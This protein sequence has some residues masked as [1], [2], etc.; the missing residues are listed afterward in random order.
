MPTENCH[1]L[2]TD[3]SAYLD[4][5]ASQ[6]LCAELERHLANCDDCTAVVD[7]AR[8]TVNLYHHLPRPEMPADARAR[9]FKTLDLSE[10][11]KA[12]P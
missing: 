2:L 3:L 10:Y 4:G 7:T 6:E 12:K 9:L 8:K 11:L 5:E 1:H